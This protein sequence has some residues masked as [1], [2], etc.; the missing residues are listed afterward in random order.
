[1]TDLATLGKW[2]A[3]LCDHFPHHASYEFRP[4]S[5]SMRVR[6]R[7]SDV[8]RPI[9]MSRTFVIQFSPDAFSAYAASSQD[10][11]LHADRQLAALVSMAMFDYKPEHDTPV[12]RLVP[13]FQLFIKAADLFPT[14]FS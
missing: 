7:L 13:E 12:G 9:K 8:N 4:P 10:L 6:W 5:S 1:M 14:E 11:K 2:A 3:L